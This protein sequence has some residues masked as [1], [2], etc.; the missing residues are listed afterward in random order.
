MLRAIGQKERRSWRR[1]APSRG[2]TQPAGVPAR[3]ADTQRGTVHAQRG[4]I[5]TSC[6]G[7]PA[8]IITHSHGNPGVNGP[9]GDKEQDASQYKPQTILAVT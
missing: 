9:S 6:L 8:A 4:R 1:Q 2:G 7:H 3:G 5:V